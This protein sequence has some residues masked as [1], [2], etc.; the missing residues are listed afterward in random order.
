MRCKNRRKIM[1]TSTKK[2]LSIVLILLGIAAVGS[3]GYDY[4]QYLEAKDHASAFSPVDSWRWTSGEI[5]QI[6][7]GIVSAGAGIS[8]L[9][10]IFAKE[11]EE[12][13]TNSK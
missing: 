3:I 5:F 1:D 6:I 11:A 10:S 2:T 13:S 12:E 4:Y 9:D 8:M 7:A